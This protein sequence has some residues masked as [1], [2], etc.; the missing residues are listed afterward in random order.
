MNTVISTKNLVFIQLVRPSQTG[1]VQ[2]VYN[3]LEIGNFQPKFDN[4]FFNHYTLYDVMQKIE[5]LETVQGVNF[6][7][8]DSLKNNDLKYSLIFGHSCKEICNSKPYVDFAADGRH[9]GLSIPYNKHNLF[10]LGDLRQDV[11]L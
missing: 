5:I 7:F 9:H 10:Q 1:L 8:V 4:S 2:F 3:L 6:D 11:E